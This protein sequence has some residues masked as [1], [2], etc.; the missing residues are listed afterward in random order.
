MIPA[1]TTAQ[2]ST[3]RT[4]I[5]ADPALAAI[6]QKPS[7][8]SDDWQAIASAMNVASAPAYVIWRDSIAVVQV[9]QNGFDW[10]RVDNATVGR[11][12]IWEW[13]TV[14]GTLNPMLANVRAGVSAAFNQAADSAMRIAI[15][16][17]FG[18]PCT[19]AE[20]LY[21]TGPGS[22]SNDAGVGP[23]TAAA[24]GDLTWPEVQSAFVT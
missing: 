9:M 18:R 21:A 13:M 11:A 1:L 24:W 23:G 8:S 15:F 19:R 10:L 22:V 2:L 20:R 6:A 3:L 16:G 4:A 14:A 12:R 17:H 5:L 7:P